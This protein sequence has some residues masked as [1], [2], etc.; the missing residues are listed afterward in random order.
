MVTTSRKPASSREKDLRLALFRIEQG[1]AHTKAKKISISSVAREAGVSAALIHNHYPSIAELIRV[2]QGAS[3]RD[4]RDAKQNELQA[5]RSKS[6]ALRAELDETKRQVAKLAS[7]NET[8]IVENETLKARLSNSNV[9]EF[10]A[11]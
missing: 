2:K 6:K 9:Y 11:R 3:S 8:L 4:H 5:E 7:L 1:R 10:P